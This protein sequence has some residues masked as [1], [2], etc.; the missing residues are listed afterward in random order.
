MFWMWKIVRRF[1]GLSDLIINRGI[2]LGIFN[3]FCLLIL[4]GHVTAIT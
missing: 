2:M 3:V 4:L 1:A